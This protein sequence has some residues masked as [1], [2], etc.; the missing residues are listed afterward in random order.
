MLDF[1][2]KLDEALRAGDQ[3]EAHRVLVVHALGLVKIF[4]YKLAPWLL[5]LIETIHRIRG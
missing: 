4:A 3:R 1:Y 5:V 2:R